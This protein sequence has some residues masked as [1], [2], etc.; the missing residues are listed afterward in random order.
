MPIRLTR[1]IKVILIVC[2]VTFIVQQTIDQFFG[3]DLVGWLGLIPSSFVLGHRF[4]QIFTY[5]FLHGDVMHLFLNLM[6]LAF[7]GPDLEAAWGQRRFLQYYFFCATAA[8]MFYLVLQILAS[9]G[10]GLHTPMIG[11]SGAIYGLL[12]AYG[13]IFGERVMLFMMLFPMKAKHF[14]WVLAGI[15]FMS[16]VFSGRGALAGAAHLG[17]M[18]AGFCYLWAWATW[19]RM[20]KRRSEGGGRGGRRR[21]SSK[22]EHLKL[23]INND[24]GGPGNKPF[25]DG[26][27]F[28]NN[29]KTWH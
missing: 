6:M 2:F 26:D 4:W 7:I 23:V 25:G 1:S 12:M 9:G 24:E 21:K 5:S 16:S 22:R 13:L 20:K 15:E 8:G 29:P 14:I 28:D 3:G 10:Q 11:A 17:G 19:A 18:A 27:D